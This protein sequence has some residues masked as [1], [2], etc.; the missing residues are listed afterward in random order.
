[1]LISD[2]LRLD[3]ADWLAVDRGTVIWET[4]D[5]AGFAPCLRL[6]GL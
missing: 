5:D 3:R 1:V 2:R 4:A 6:F